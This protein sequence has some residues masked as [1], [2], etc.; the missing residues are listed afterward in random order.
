M[1]YIA[2]VRS[3]LALCAIGALLATPRVSAQDSKLSDKYVVINGMADPAAIPEYAA[4]RNALTMFAL[5]E[6]KTSRELKDELQL[7]TAEYELLATEARQ[8]KARRD[9]CHHRQARVTEEGKQA[10]WSAARF[11][12]AIDA[13][14]LAKTFAPDEN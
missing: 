11:Q 10:G 13:V 5:R 2:R 8:E 9:A 4:W 3:A 6:R 7:P 1:T 12:E 14:V